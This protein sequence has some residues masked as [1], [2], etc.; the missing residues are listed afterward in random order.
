M[1]ALIVALGGTAYAASSLPKNSVGSKQLKKNSV[2]TAKI[3]NGAVTGKKIR[4]KSLGTVPSATHA[5]SADNA[6]NATNAG[7]A[8][9][10]D[11]ASHASN[12]DTATNANNLGGAPPSTYALSGQ[13]GY[14]AAT[15]NTGFTNFGSGWSTAGFL[16]DTLGY[17]H[18]KGTMNCTSGG[19]AFTLPAEDRPSENLF[20]PMAQGG[21][22]A[23][24]EVLTN[25][26]VRTDT[27]SN[28]TC[29]IDGLVFKV[30]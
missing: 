29:G 28:T 12:A 9:S 13:P 8:N 16:K 5:L 3:K 10:A 20:M 27:T 21:G 26:N 24:V 19:T 7:H 11:N 22:A 4:L 2:T 25:G 15:L 30:G 1:I 18:L 23:N 6:T 17:V 14:T